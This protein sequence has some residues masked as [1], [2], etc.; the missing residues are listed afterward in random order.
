[1][2]LLLGFGGYGNCV[3]TIIFD[4]GITRCKIL[5]GMWPGCGLADIQL[6]AL[7]SERSDRSPEMQMIRRSASHAAQAFAGDFDSPLGSWENLTIPKGYAGNP[8]LRHGCGVD[9]FLVERCRSS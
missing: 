6:S 9:V 5:T 3:M 1:M 8:P 7:S 2:P 4:Q